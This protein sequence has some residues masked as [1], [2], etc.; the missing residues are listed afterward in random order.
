MTSFELRLLARSL[1][2][3]ES[4]Q[5]GI[6]VVTGTADR[7]R[8]GRV[9]ADDVELERAIDLALETA[10]SLEEHLRP[11]EEEA[12]LEEAVG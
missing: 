7:V 1:G 12:D 11:E 8:F 6:Q 5:R 10:F 2:W 9:A 3:P 4:I